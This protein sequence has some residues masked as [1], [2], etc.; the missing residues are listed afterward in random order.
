[1]DRTAQGLMTPGRALFVVV[2]VL[3]FIVD[4]LTKGLVNASVELGHEV[5]LIP[6]VVWITNTRNAGAAFGMAQSAALVFLAASIVVSVAIIY[7]QFRNPTTLGADV[8][9]GL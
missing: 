2:A 8:L 4:R 7:Y 5:P 9:L 1:M 3:V 6:G